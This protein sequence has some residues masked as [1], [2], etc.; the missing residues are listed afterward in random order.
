[1]LFRSWDAAEAKRLAKEED[2]RRNKEALA[3]KFAH[4]SDDPSKP[5]VEL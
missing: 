5:P 2:E 4:V 3:A 1:M